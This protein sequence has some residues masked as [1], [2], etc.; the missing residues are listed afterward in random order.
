MSSHT[1][2]PTLVL[3]GGYLQEITVPKGLK[4]YVNIDKEGIPIKT[5]LIS[6]LLFIIIVVCFN[7]ITTIFD[8]TFNDITKADVDKSYRITRSLIYCLF[9]TS[10]CLFLIL[11]IYFF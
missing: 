3:G 7:L 1:L 11:I 9:L 6:V 2:L 10:I 4:G 5:S 8:S